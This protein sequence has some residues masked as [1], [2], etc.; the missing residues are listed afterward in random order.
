MPSPRRKLP[1]PAWVFIATRPRLALAAASS[2][3]RIASPFM[4]RKLYWI[5]IW[6]IQPHSAAAVTISGSRRSWQLSPQKRILPDF[7]SFSNAAL[8]S[9]SLK[10]R[11][12]ASLDAVEVVAIDV[13][14]P[15]PLEAR[16]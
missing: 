7:L 15:E 5:M 9:G 16:R 11:D 14:G 13:V 4:V 6:S 8:T 3:R 10:Q 12:L 2:A 1:A